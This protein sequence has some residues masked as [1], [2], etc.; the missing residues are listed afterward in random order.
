[1]RSIALA[2]ALSALAAATA[3]AQEPKHPHPAPRDTGMAGMPGMKKPA[4][5]DTAKARMPATKKPA[6]PRDTA[7]AGMPGMKK[8]ARRDTGMAGMPGMNR[9]ARDSGMAGMQMRQGMGGM[10]MAMTGPLGIS[11]SRDG[12]GTAWQPDV[13]PMYALQRTAGRWMLMFHGNAFLQS[14]H[15]GSRRGEQQLGSVNWFMGMAQR[16]LAGGDLAL[17]GM[18]SL[19]PLTVGKCGYPDVLATGELC[20]GRPLHDRQHPHDAFMEVAALYQR[21]LTRNLAV[22][23]YGGPAGEP[24]LG[25]VAFPH[26]ISALWTPLAPISHHWQDAT[27]IAFGVVT[28]GV[29]GR[30]WKVEGSAFNGREPDDQRFDFDLGALDSYSG[31]VWLLPTDRIAL[32]LSNGYLHEAERSPAGV[33]SDVHRSTASLTYHLPV[34]GVGF[35]ANT[36]VWGQNRAHGL[37]TSASL[38]ESSLDLDG[39]NVVY[40]RGELAQKSGEDLALEQEAPALADR[41]FSVGKLAVGYTRQ[42]TAGAWRPGIGAEL[43]L[44]FVPSALKPFYGS[45]TSAG[46]AVYASVRPAPMRM[47]AHQAM[48]P[49]RAPM[50][51]TMMAPPDTSH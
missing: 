42:L 28:A 30:R 20:N 29:Y 4:P 46:F 23:L 17:R 51:K 15:D 48:A 31:R 22:E 32:Q 44:N 24:A 19:E 33:R 14:I 3:F 21:A 34:R 12:S 7:M 40:G 11:E 41:V 8:P 26:R 27:H 25:P 10:A 13:T 36:L 6:A 50:P 5:R 37:V 38:V 16:P 9:P 2:L 47:D 35:W 1:M 39:R 18:L 49:V 45:T 43:S